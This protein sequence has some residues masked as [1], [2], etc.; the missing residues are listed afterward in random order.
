MNPRVEF[1]AH[2]MSGKVWELGIEDFGAESMT[3]ALSHKPFTFET[4]REP[5]V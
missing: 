4:I 1:G 3:Q 5:R 2:G